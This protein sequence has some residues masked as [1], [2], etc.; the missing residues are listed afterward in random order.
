MRSAIGIVAPYVT[1]VGLKTVIQPF[2]EQTDLL[3]YESLGKLR[4][5][6]MSGEGNRPYFV[7]FFVDADILHRNAEFFISLPQMTIAIS[8]GRTFPDKRFPCLDISASEEEFYKQ[9]LSLRKNDA[10]PA[11][12]E[13]ASEALT[14]REIDVL[15]CVAKGMINKQIADKLCISLTT[16]ITHRQHITGKLG[17]KSVAALTVYAVLHGIIDYNE[18]V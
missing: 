12:S 18:I 15:R 8:N 4:K 2:F 3:I 11:E 7:H 5:Q 10:R 14:A 17:L 6:V 1:A 9:M 13:A 16:V